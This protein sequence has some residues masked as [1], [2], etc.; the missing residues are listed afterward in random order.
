MKGPSLTA[1]R[2]DVIHDLLEGA[3]PDFRVFAQVIQQLAVRRRGNIEIVAAD[4][5]ELEYA[6]PVRGTHA[7][8]VGDQL[9]TVRMVDRTPAWTVRRSSRA[10]WR[11]R[12]AGAAAAEGQRPEGQGQ[13][14]DH[15]RSGRAGRDPDGRASRGADNPRRAERKPSAWLEYRRSAD[16]SPEHCTTENTKA[17]RCGRSV[18]TSPGRW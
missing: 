6:E 1:A 2:D 9:L 8:R 3:D 5:V 17:L 18:S 15:H 16:Q 7:F 14:L 13:D 10:L 4:A 11:T 12:P